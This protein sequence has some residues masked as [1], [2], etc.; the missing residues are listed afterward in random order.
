MTTAV[1]ELNKAGDNYRNYSVTKVVP[2]QEIHCTLRELQHRPTGATI[3]HIDADDSENV[4]CLAFRTTPDRSDGVAHILEH[5]VLCGSEKYAVHDPFFSMTRR[6]LNTFMNAFTGQDFTCYPAASQ[7]RTDFYNLLDVYCDAVF[8]PK[9]ESFAFQQEGH[10]IEFD[11][12]EDASTDLVYRGI[13]FNEMKGALSSPSARFWEA[14]GAALFPDVTYGIN[15]GG[16]PSVIPSLTYEQ[17]IQFH[18]DY[19]HPGR[20]LF[21]FY[22]NLPLEGHL[23]FL[24]QAV[25]EGQSNP[26]PLPAIPRQ[27]RF[28]SPKHVTVPYPV[29]ADEATE[30]KTYLGFAW[31]TCHVL[32]QA[33]AL[34]LDVLETILMDNDASPLRKVLLR[35]GLCKEAEMALVEDIN[36]LPLILQ[37]RGCDPE[38]AD[39]IEDLILDTLR[40]I[41]EEGISE[42][43]IE[44]AL[45]QIELDRLEIS[46]DSYPY[47][48][49]LFFRAGLL[50]QHG[51]APEE[52]LRIHTLFEELRR[53]FRQPHYL[54]SLIERY[55]IDNP[56]RV[57]LVMPPDTQLNQRESEAER[58]VLAEIKAGLDKKE[59]DLIVKKARTLQNYQ[60]LH[61]NEDMSCLPL[62]GMDEIPADCRQFPLHQEKLAGCDILHHDVFTNDIVYVDLVY[63]LPDVG[64]DKHWLLQLFTHL[65]PQ[66]GSAGRDYA[67]NLQL[68]QEHTGGLDA[69]LALHSQARAPHKFKPSLT[70]GGKAL[71]RKAE[72]FFPLLRDMIVS[73]DFTDRVRIEE[74]LNKHYIGLEQSLVNGALRYAMNL[75]AC[76]VSSSAV[77]QRGLSGL[78]Y[79][80]CIR[81]LMQD[82]PNR[83]DQLVQDLQALSDLV[84]CREQG[85][86][87]ISTDA[88]GYATMLKERFWGLLD[89]KPRF[90][91]AWDPV[92]DCVP[93]A[94]QG[95]IIPSGVAFTG[96]VVKGVPYTQPEAAPLGLAAKI[97]NNRVL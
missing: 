96:L 76:K 90:S 26:G 78:D 24:D 92:V 64:E 89:Y 94:S 25:F 35:S 12:P 68:L 84:L 73:P 7:V 6:S 60:D 27:R 62:I 97:A 42:A 49:S 51:G 33:D 69:S 87:V 2:L 86:L 31:L 8:K 28:H 57:R 19:Y 13:V 67:A 93:V 79:F 63:D 58:K 3:L 46:G 22:G 91:P 44:S 74:L 11:D 20:C 14:I 66:M 50:R 54:S 77:L 95:L 75:S 80:R 47:G 52:A 82:L 65:L 70:L 88:A 53:N 41:A 18:R 81:A 55:L 23:D 43:M 56:H 38:N 29:A 85:K 48:L 10:R 34:A 40:G 37:L 39:K 16:D 30:G 5:T 21:F 9:L 36:E 72:H 71:H 1:T 4:F 17:L 59:A 32:E 61:E 45:H 15:S 83:M